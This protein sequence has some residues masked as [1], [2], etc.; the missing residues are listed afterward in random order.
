M[1]SLD[2]ALR[3]AETA[4]AVIAGI[5][6]AFTMVLVSTDAILRHVFS[7]P[8]GWQFMLT[9]SYLMVAGV[10]LAL[11]WGYRTGGRIRIMLLMERVPAGP[12][13]LILRAGNLV[14]V[15]YLAV[16][17]WKTLERTWEAFAE[18]DVMMGVID[19][20]VAWSWVWIP[21]GLGLLT[22][23]VLHDAFADVDGADGKAH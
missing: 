9:E 14:A 19:W 10:A 20:P 5:V 6:I 18:G 22:L 23:R 2:G 13:R 21:M 4:L 16:F 1:A 11:P 17:T 3:A 15:P 7:S 8:L 12:R